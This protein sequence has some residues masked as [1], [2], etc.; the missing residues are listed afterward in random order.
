MSGGIRQAAVI[1]A[2]A[3][4]ALVQGCTEK[5]AGPTGPT[6]RVYAADLAG[7][8]KQCD[9]PKPI[10]TAGKAVDASM[11]VGND[12]G[13]C[14]LVIHQPGPKPYDAGLLTARPAHGNV[15]IHSVGDDTRID[16]VPDRGYAGADAFTV[17]LVPGLP[18]VNVAVTVTHG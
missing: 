8:A 6:L 11:M 13:W 3:A 5:P 7:G 2:F 4:C 16:Y 15:T 14:G 12:G 1:A 10:L 9:V 18:A 17:K